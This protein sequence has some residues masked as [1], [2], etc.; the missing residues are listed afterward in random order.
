MLLRLWWA[1]EPAPCGSEAP[2]SEDPHVTV[3]SEDLWLHQPRHDQ[4]SSMCWRTVTLF[5]GKQQVLGWNPQGPGPRVAW[6]KMVG[7]D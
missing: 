4:H 7:K 3:T 6:E 2:T 5:Y 1:S